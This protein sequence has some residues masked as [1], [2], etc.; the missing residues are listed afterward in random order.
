MKV[1]LVNKQNFQVVQ[2]TT[3]GNIA[4]NANANSVTFTLTGGGSGG[5]YSLDTYYMSIIWE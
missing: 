4:Y 3:V 2:I 5:S 1:L